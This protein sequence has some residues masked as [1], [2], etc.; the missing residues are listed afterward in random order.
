MMVVPKALVLLIW[1]L[2]DFSL[3]VEVNLGSMSLLQIITTFIL[4]AQPIKMNV[5][6]Y[7]FLE[8]ISNYCCLFVI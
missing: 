8:V 1:R 6:E 7:E 5:N 2:F 4:T 3:F